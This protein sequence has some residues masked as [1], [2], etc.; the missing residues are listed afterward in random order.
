MVVALGE[1]MAKGELTS[2]FRDLLP[3]S[4]ALDKAERQAMRPRE[5][6]GQV[7]EPPVVTQQDYEETLTAARK[8]MAEL[9][10]LKA[11]S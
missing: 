6:V 2:T 1:R 9:K 4:I 5:D 7:S 3:V 11:V 10:G 8:R